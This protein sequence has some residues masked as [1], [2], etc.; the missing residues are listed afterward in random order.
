MTPT[1]EGD[2][3]DA[4]LAAAVI[5]NTPLPAS[6]GPHDAA[7]LGQLQD[8]RV[9]VD[10]Y[11]ALG[12]QAPLATSPLPFASWGPLDLVEELGRGSSGS[13]FRAHDRL[14][15]QDVALKV[16]NS[17]SLSSAV[18]SVARVRHPNVVRVLGT[19]IY[20]G[21]AGLWMEYVAGRTLAARVQSDGPARW[22][23]V[24]RIGVELC[25]A[26]CALHEAGLVHNAVRT[27]SVKDDAG[28]IVLLDPGSDQ[29]SD[30]AVSERGLL[31]LAPEVLLG[32]PPS[33]QSD[34]YSAGVVLYYLLTGTYPL[35]SPSLEEMRRLHER[36]QNSGGLGILVGALALQ[37]DTPAGLAQVVAK[38]LA[39]QSQRYQSAQELRSALQGLGRRSASVLRARRVAAAALLGLILAV[40]GRAISRRADPPPPLA[41]RAAPIQAQGETDQAIPADTIPHSAAPAGYAIDAALYVHR[42]DATQP[43]AS[44]DHVREGERLIVRVS[45]SRPFYFYVFGQSAEGRSHLMFPLSRPDC[46]SRNPVPPRQDHSLPGKCGG[47]EAAWEVRSHGG[48]ARFLLLASP[49]RLG[50][51]EQAFARSDRGEEELRFRQIVDLAGRKGSASGTG[52][53]WIKDV[54]LDSTAP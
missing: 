20:E 7:L 52:E 43:L 6:T 51:L 22:D 38:A 13:V 40:G 42:G 11:E 19:G 14:A 8:L 3:D 36:Q 1:V 32:Q 9:I 17:G 27:S 31:Y 5:E 48:Q 25:N 15:R 18:L 44:G 21:R 35:Y 49:T 45:G 28:R 41:P 37:P 12:Q 26:L 10:A 39:P 33:F 50:R 24:V 29:F 47:Q 23:E 53:V 34:V 54:V 46:E 30:E 4:R 16:Y 2:E